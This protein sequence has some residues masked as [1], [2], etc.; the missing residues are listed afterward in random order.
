MTPNR[1]A[2]LC[3][4][5]ALGAPSAPALAQGAAEQTAPAPAAAPKASPRA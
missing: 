1:I 5:I 2:T 4:A 3:L